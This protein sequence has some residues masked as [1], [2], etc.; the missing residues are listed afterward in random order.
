MPVLKVLSLL[1]DFSFQGLNGTDN[2]TLITEKPFWY[3]KSN[4]IDFMLVESVWRGKNNQWKYKIAGYPNHPKRNN[5]KLTKLVTWAKDHHIPTVFWNKEDPYH[6]EQFIDSAK[7]FDYIFTTDDQSI[8]RYKKDAP[9]AKVHVLPFFIQT[10][11]H[12]PQE[13][14]TKNRSLFIG[15]YHH[16]EH[17]ERKIWQD[18]IFPQAAKYG[19]TIIDRHSSSTSNLKKFP[20]YQGD[21][22]YIDAIPYNQ[23][24][25]MYNQFSHCLNV[26]S[27]TNSNTM[28]S[29]RLLEIMACGKLAI[30]N[31]SKAIDNLFDE[32]CICIDDPLEANELFK[33][34]SSGYNIEQIEMC[35]F[36]QD[37]VY[38]N[39]NVENW[40][41]QILKEIN[42]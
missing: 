14:I 12:K 11:L 7:L 41:N 28:F 1:D 2:L 8:E 17:P 10:N 29:R 30:S 19:L 25:Q 38:K 15:S 40:I 20:Y 16:T 27:I 32:M 36:A 23:T 33:Q 21:L 42:I 26:N 13:I 6:Y 39:Y 35:K 4:K 24:Q 22:E 3:R 37:H 5:N 34:L 31:P 9:N 18:Q